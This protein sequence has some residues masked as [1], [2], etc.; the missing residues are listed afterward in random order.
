MNRSWPSKTLGAFAS[1]VNKRVKTQSTGDYAG[2]LS[3]I[4]KW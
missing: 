1:A 3:V 4:A 2:A